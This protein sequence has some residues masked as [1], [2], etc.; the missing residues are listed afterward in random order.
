MIFLFIWFETFSQG[1]VLT[2][3]ILG[4]YT[5]IHSIYDIFYRAKTKIIIDKEANM[6]LRETT[7][8]KKEIC[9]C[10][11]SVV[12]V[13]KNMGSWHYA[14]GHKKKYL[15]QNYRI[16]EDFYNLRKESKS[17]AEYEKKILKPVIELLNSCQM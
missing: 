11:N 4:G 7:F 10:C 6:V 8:K 9:E 12:F 13:K 2:I 14:I 1:W 16:S 15:Y 3:V 5:I 17:Q